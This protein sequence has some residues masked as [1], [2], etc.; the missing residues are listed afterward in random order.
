M[1][2]YL[3]TLGG[4]EQG[5]SRHN[6]ENIFRS[7]QLEAERLKSSA[8]NFDFTCIIYSNEFLNNLPYR[9]SFS[10]VMDKVSFGFSYKAI[11]IWETLIRMEDDDILLMVDSNHVFKKYPNFIFEFVR[12]NDC[13]TWYHSID[14]ADSQEDLFANQ[15]FTKKGTFVHMNCDSHEYW[16]MPQVQCNVLAFK[17][18]KRI[19]N[20]CR[21]FFCYSINPEVMFGLGSYKNHKDFKVHRHDQSIFTNLVKKYNIEVF[22]PNLYPR[23]KKIIYEE[24]FIQTVV[25]ERNL[26][27]RSADSEFNK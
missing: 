21:E 24:K 3:V 17:K 20:M 13:F 23:S 22:N 2:K 5:W 12:S 16:T 4:Y 18:C 1:K 7:Y 27:R 8:K 25:S 26:H 11:C 14:P 9:K 10:E 15:K 6:E 19:L